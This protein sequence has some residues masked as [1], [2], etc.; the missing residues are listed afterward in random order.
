[1]EVNELLAR[2]RDELMV[3][4]EMDDKRQVNRRRDSL[5]TEDE[6]PEWVMHGAKTKETAEEVKI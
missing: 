5:M 4:E 3:F 2:N 6:L 1:M